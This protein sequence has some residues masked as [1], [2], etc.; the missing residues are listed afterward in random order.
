MKKYFLTF[1]ITLA[2]LICFAFS[3][4]AIQK[5]EYIIP[6]RESAPIIDGIG[7]D[8]EWEGAKTIYL[9]TIPGHNRRRESRAVR[10]LV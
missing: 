4:A 1:T 9:S 10:Y 8:P 3:S 6:L 5:K 7:Y 2:A